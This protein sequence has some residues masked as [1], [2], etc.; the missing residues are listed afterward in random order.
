[1]KP[2]EVF[3]QMKRDP[4]FLLKDYS[5]DMLF[6]GTLVYSLY[7][8]K[9]NL[10]FIFHPLL[11]LALIV[12]IPFGW[13][14][15]AFLHKAGHENVTKG[16]V[17]KIIGEFV[18]HFVG[19]GFHNFI[20][21]HTLH[22]LYSDH[23]Y[24]PVSPRGMSFTRYLLSPNKYMIKNTKEFLRDTHK[25]IESYETILTLQSFVFHT[26]MILRLA[27]WF[28]IF[29]PALFLFFYLP[30]VISN[31]AILAHINYV[32]HRDLDDGSVEVFNMNHNAYYK[33]AN[34]V[35]M[36][37]YFHKNHHQNLSLF[38]PRKLNNEKER[39]LTLKASTNGPLSKVEIKPDNSSL[40]KYFNLDRV[41]EEKGS[42]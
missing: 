20:L 8:F 5:L 13:L 2:A 37:G 31:I 6:L 24:D 14:V 35:T 26:N 42:L 1:M 40:R 11:I 19:Y 29:G 39:L 9:T 25:N 27:A 3:K 36:G 34:F 30:A 21:V 41:W 23:K 32:C 22:H 33:L 17:N 16:P 7:F 28:M 15:A 10:E 18:G 38:D 12:A 4:Y